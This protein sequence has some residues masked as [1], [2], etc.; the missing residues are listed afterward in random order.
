MKPRTACF[1]LLLFMAGCGLATP[2]SSR[3][4]SESASEPAPPGE[5]VPVELA[6][7]GI[8]LRTNDP[9]V[10]LLEES[11][12][13]A[14]PIWIGLEE[15]RAIML[16]LHGIETPRPMTH[17][18][19][20]NLLQEL[21]AHVEEV[22]VHEI[23][24]GTYY[25]AIRLRSGDGSTAHEV[26]S[27]PSDALA[28]AARIDAPIR[29]A[30]EILVDVP[31]IEFM[32]P[33]DDEQV[34]RLLGMT[35]VAATPELRTEFEL[36]D[37]PGV[38]VQD[39]AGTAAAAG[40]RGGDLIVEVNG[41]VPREPMDVFDAVRATAAGEPVI[42]TFWRDGEEHTAEIQLDSPTRPRT[43][44]PPRIRL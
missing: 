18:L 25:G 27:R 29:V 34:V 37:R 44:E 2:D 12:G 7:V 19:M 3:S 30:S 43:V 26:D 33:E 8:D 6:T 24:N 20:V 31:E 1:T 10:L 4:D 40:L 38:V 36:P 41:N 13:K 17:D 16:A 22:V 15:A 9:V 39:A 28:L 23:R 11:S 5:L 42:I 14:V 32:A 35:L 21:G